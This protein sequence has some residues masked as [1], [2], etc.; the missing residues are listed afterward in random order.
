MKAHL[1]IDASQTWVLKHDAM[2][3]GIGDNREKFGVAVAKQI[4]CTMSSPT[5]VKNGTRDFGAHHM[6]ECPAIVRGDPRL[7][8][9]VLVC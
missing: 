1:W 5:F 4:G 6:L 7:Q 2:H 9:A 3:V 8:K